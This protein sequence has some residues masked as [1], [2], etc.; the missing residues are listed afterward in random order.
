MMKS[1][2]KKMP[3]GS[4]LAY[5]LIVLSLMLAI[6][7]GVSVTSGIQRKNAG[8]TEKT[9]QALQVA[10]S[11]VEAVT[12]AVFKATNPS[13]PLST[14][15]CTGSDVPASGGTYN[16]QFLDKNGDILA[17]NKPISDLASVKSTGDFG[18][19]SR[20]VE[21]A[22]AVSLTSRTCSVTFVGANAV[23]VII[24]LP[25]VPGK[26]TNLCVDAEGCRIDIVKYDLSNHP[27]NVNNG[28]SDI[29]TF[30]QDSSD[31]WASSNGAIFGRNGIGAIKLVA[32]SDS[33][34]LSIYDD[35]L[36][37]SP[38]KCGSTTE[39]SKDALTATNDRTN[40][41]FKVIVCD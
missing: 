4:V 17:C 40:F 25:I 6:S 13:Q 19:T 34:N 7:I 11:G 41:G 36:P 1:K 5:S 26:A 24:N 32:A 33:A 3:K 35:C 39:T 12:Q 37:S 30:I 31:Y 27:V 2:L 20:A 10:S 28:K 8:T 9:S 23:G 14:V 21:V 22:V 38:G 18:N 16:L 15:G 29:I